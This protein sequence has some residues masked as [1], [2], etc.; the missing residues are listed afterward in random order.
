MLFNNRPTNNLY[1]VY[2]FVFVGLFK[3]FI[4]SFANYGKVS[5][6]TAPFNIK[7]FLY[8]VKEL[9]SLVNDRI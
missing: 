6:P 5:P 9:R 2:Q 3:N 1:C 4:G 7:F 8:W